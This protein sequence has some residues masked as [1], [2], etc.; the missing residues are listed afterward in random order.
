MTES[1]LFAFGSCVV[2]VFLV[3]CYLTLRRA[4]D[5]T[6]A[7]EFEMVPAIAS[8]PPKK[9]DHLIDFGEA[10]RPLGQKSMTTNG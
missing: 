8:T 3:G 1:T 4:F 10:F 7:S 5:R 2:F 6:R 9:T